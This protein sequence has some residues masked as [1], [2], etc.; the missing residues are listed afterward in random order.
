MPLYQISM[1]VKVTTRVDFEVDV[2]AEVVAQG[3]AAINLYAR[4]HA[5]DWRD[6]AFSQEETF[7]LLEMEPLE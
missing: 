5:P 3:A 7:D 6:D 4:A 1:D 2:P